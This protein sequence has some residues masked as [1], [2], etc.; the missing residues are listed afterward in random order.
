METLLA[1]NGVE[2]AKKWIKKRN[3]PKKFKNKLVIFL[4]FL[5]LEYFL[6]EILP[7]HLKMDDEIKPFDMEKVYKF[8]YKEED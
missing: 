6:L 7:Y 2:G 8:I 3:S 5:Y 1:L 4:P